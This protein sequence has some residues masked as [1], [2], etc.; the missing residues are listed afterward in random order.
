MSF[1][2]PVQ[3]DEFDGLGNLSRFTGGDKPGAAGR[4]NA[5]AASALKEQARF[6][7]NGTIATGTHVDGAWVAPFA[8][9]IT[10]VRAY[11]RVAG[12]AG[13]TTVDVNIGG[14]SVFAVAGD[15][16]SIAN[17]DPDGTVSSKAPTA[18]SAGT[19]G[20]FAAG[21]VI[22]MDVDVAPTAGSDLTVLVEL[23]YD[24]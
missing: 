2:I 11:A 23:D 10:R 24:A 13:D 16:P 15:R 5:L 3:T 14:T 8:G 21:A 19:V 6:V 22:T 7:Q 18:I 1:K 17:T 4:L 9:K 20:G 12:T